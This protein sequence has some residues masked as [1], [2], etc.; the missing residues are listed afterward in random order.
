KVWSKTDK[1]YVKQYEEE[2]NLRCT[3]VVDVSNS[4][5][6]GRGALNKYNYGCTIGACLAYML[7]RQQDAVGCITFDEDVRQIVPARSSHNHIDAVIRARAVSVPRDK[8]TTL[9]ILQRVAENPPPGGMIVIAPALFGAR[10]PL[11]RGL[12][13]LRHARHDILVF[14]VLDEDEM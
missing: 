12:K 11:F 7:L 8:T 13:M 9:R 14:H 4:M 1:F 2:T 3:V 10:E 5:H 6:Y